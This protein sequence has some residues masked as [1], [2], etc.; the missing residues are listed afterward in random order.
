MSKTEEKSQNEKKKVEKFNILCRN[1]LILI[2][3]GDEQNTESDD[4]K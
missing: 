2:R 1:E 4:K 3:G